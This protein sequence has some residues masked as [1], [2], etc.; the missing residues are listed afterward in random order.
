MRGMEQRRCR[1]SGT[2]KDAGIQTPDVLAAIDPAR[3]AASM[4]ECAAQRFSG[5]AKSA[6]NGSLMRTAP[7]AL[8]YLDHDGRAGDDATVGAAIAVS[9]LTHGDP[10]CADACV[11]WCLAIRHAVLTG[12]LDIRRGLEGL[13]ADRRMLWSARLDEAEQ[14]LP[15]DIPSNGWVVG[16]LLQRG[17]PSLAQRSPTTIRSVRCSGPTI[18]GTHWLRQSAAATTPTPSRPSPAACSVR[19]TVCSPFRRRGGECCRAGQDLVLED[20]PT[21]PR[22]FFAA[23]FPTPSTTAMPA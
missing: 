13:A 12:E 21:C 17:T 1:S 23:A 19:C 7:V 18:C 9:D 15:Q 22:Q 8:A 3:P 5:G 2:A 20:W 6:G 4:L 14:L 11:L 10:D 16:A